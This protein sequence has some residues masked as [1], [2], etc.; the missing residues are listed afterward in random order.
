MGSSDTNKTEGS[1]GFASP[2]SNTTYT[3]NQFFDVVLPHSSRAVIRIVGYLIRKVLGWTDEY[4]HSQQSQVR[5][6]YDQLMEKLNFKNPSTVSEALKFATHYNFITCAC[7]GHGY[8]KG[9]GHQN[10]L[11][12]LKWSERT[13][14]VTDLA[15]F[16][17][18]YDEVSYFTYV[19]NEYFDCVLPNESEAVIK[20][21]GKVMR[22][23]IG[24]KGAKGGHRKRV[25]GISYSQFQEV[26]S[27]FSSIRKGI[28]DAAKRNYIEVDEQ[29]F[30]DKSGKRGPSTRYRIKWQDAAIY[31]ETTLKSVAENDSKKCSNKIKQQNKTFKQQQPVVDPKLI[32]QIKNYIPGL[33]EAVLLELVSL[34]SEPRVWKE[35]DAMKGGFRSFQDKAAF[36]VAALK[37]DYPLPDRYYQEREK[38]E[39]AAAEARK[40][41]EREREQADLY[42]VYA[43]DIRKVVEAEIE[44]MSDEQLQQAK[45]EAR[46][47]LLRDHPEARGWKA[48]VLEPMLEKMLR[49]EIQ[50]TLR[51]PGF[52]NWLEQNGHTAEAR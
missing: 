27:S 31:D 12:E 44:R 37:N 17:G 20:V 28:N 26:L 4:G 13:G 9:S 52:T 50:Q 38:K 3:P 5:V 23:T 6:S 24:W 8:Q 49:R 29:G 16:A 46:R 39:R 30:F 40:G 51:L 15:E 48:E 41:A 2:T 45:V 1:K 42:Q 11:Y 21:V 35:I 19:P 36:F 34:R 7:Q 14:Y 22:N 43:Q 33:D 18:F 32:S 47:A 25:D 10:S